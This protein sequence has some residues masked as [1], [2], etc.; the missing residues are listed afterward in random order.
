[1]AEPRL[2][3]IEPWTAWGRFSSPANSGSRCPRVSRSFTD[4]TEDHTDVVSLSGRE[5][6][7]RSVG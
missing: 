1:M 2:R 4:A 3:T 7:D 5:G 6:L